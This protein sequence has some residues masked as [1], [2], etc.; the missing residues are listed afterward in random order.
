MSSTAFNQTDDAIYGVY[1]PESLVSIA[2]STDA[3]GRVVGPFGM[4]MGNT[5]NEFTVYLKSSTIPEGF[6]EGWDIAGYD[7]DGNAI[8]VTVVT[9]IE[10]EDFKDAIDFEN[11]KTFAPAQEQDILLNND[12]KEEIIL[13]KNKMYI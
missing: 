6:N 4:A 9:G 3:Q 7:A 13:V 11:V 8:K 5:N 10:L 1:I 12:K 2:V